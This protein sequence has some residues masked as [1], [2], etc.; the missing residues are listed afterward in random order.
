MNKKEQVEALYSKFRQ[1]TETAEQHEF[2]YLLQY[3]MIISMGY[4]DLQENWN[5]EHADSFIRRV[6][7]S[8]KQLGIEV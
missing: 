8:L 4:R 1:Y 5:E 7:K 3:D 6:T 2:P